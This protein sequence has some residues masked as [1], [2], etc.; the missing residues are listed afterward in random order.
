MKKKFVVLPIEGQ[1]IC[2]HDYYDRLYIVNHSMVSVTYKDT[3]YFPYTKGE[4]GCGLCSLNE[5]VRGVET[6]LKMIR[7]GT[8]DKFSMDMDHSEE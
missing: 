1:P 4:D 2:C 7:E 5:K 3:L 6:V 8:I